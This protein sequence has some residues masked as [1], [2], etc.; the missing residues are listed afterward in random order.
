MAVARDG[1]PDLAHGFWSIPKCV[2]LAQSAPCLSELPE[3]LRERLSLTVQDMC[4]LHGDQGPSDLFLRPFRRLRP[5]WCAKSTAA[6]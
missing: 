2:H 1:R 4:R 5:A 3:L 6:F